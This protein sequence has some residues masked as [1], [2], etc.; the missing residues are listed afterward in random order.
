MLSAPSRTDTTG[1]RRSY[2]RFVALGDSA[3][4]GVGDRAGEH[5]RGWSRLLVGAMSREHDVSFLNIAA[6]GARAADARFHQLREALE[7]RPHIAS[8]IVGINDVLRPD[9]DADAVR[10]DLV[11]CAE[12]LSAQGALLMTAR[13]HDHTRVFRLPRFLARP[14]RA[15]IDALNAA[16]DEIHERFGGIRLDL[17]AHPGVYDRE[18]WSIDRLHPSKLG[19]RALADE[20]AAQLA[21]LGLSFDP[22]GLALDGPILSARARARIVVTEV[23]PWVGRRLKEL[24]PAALTIVQR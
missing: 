7:H 6:P 23:V 11:H 9:W 20:F 24:A 14:M 2:V 17:A 21:Q 10:R 13:F 22:P 8:L 3:T 19:H 4:Y 5:C 16:Y 18:F 15:R 12:Q 1:T